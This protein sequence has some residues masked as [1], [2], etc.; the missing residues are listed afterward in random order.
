MD[1]GKLIESGTHRELQAMGG[2][3][4]ELVKQQNLDD[5]A[6]SENGGICQ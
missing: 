4:A 6:E 2:K 1:K 3:Y 5:T